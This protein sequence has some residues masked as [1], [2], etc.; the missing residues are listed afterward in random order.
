[1][2]S[3]WLPDSTTPMDQRSGLVLGFAAVPEQAI[4]A[5]LQRLRAVWRGR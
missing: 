5:A 2:S 1:L 4:E 3:Y